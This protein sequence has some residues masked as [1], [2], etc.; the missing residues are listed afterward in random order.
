MR[1]LIPLILLSWGLSAALPPPAAAD[2]QP[3]LTLYT[4]DIDS[5]SERE[6]EQWLGRRVGATHASY[7]AV[8]SRS[9]IEYGITDNFQGSLYL[10]YEWS[11]LNPHSPTYSVDTQSFAGVSGELIYRLLNAD[12]D[13]LGF[14]LYVEPSWSDEEREVE[15]KLLLQ[16]N[17]L[18]DALRAAVNINFEDD[19]GREAGGWQQA[20]AIEFDTGL[21]YS[22]TPEWSAGLEFDNERAFDGLILGAA[23]S[24]RA[25]AW[26]LGP[27]ID[28]TGIPLTVITIG[29]QAQLPWA[30]SPTNDG[31]VAQGFETPAERFRLTLR[32]S[33]DF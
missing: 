12:F 24:E 1:R 4:T 9:E 30:T 19:W 28:Y 27:T 5:Q 33:R 20:S 23:S 10:N 22:I 14:A 25:S 31:D 11:R 6:F 26:Y 32:L 2:D 15:A 7:D 3:F 17:F 21:A 13:P 18:N 8:L 16:K 29:A